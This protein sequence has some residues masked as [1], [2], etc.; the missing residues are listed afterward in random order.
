L[1]WP[2]DQISEITIQ[3][4][5]AANDSQDFVVLVVRKQAGVAT[6]YEA[7]FAHTATNGFVLTVYKR[8]AGTPTQIAQVNN[9]TFSGTGNV[10]SFAALGS[11]LS[12]YLN[13][14]RIA[15]V[16]DATLTGGSPGFYQFTQTTVANSKVSAW[17]GYNAVQQDGIWKKQ[18]IALAPIAGDLTAGI[19]CHS[20]ILREGNAQVL[21]G[22]VYKMWFDN[23]AGVF[24]AE[25]TD[26]INWTRKASAVLAGGFTNSA[27]YKVGSTYYLYVEP[28]SGPGG[29][30]SVYTSSDGIT[31]TLQNSSAIAAGSVGAWDSVNLGGLFAVT[32]QAGTW[33]G[34]YGGC[35]DLTTLAFSSGL[36]TSSD[37]I[38]WVKS[39]S[40]PVLNGKGNFF[41]IIKVGGTYYA[42]A[43][44]NQPGQG[45]ANSPFF[46][47]SE[48]RRYKSTDLINWSIDG[49]G[50]SI[51]NG[52]MCESLN[53]NTGYAT[54]GNFINIGGVAY[55]YHTSGPGDAVTPIIGQIALAIGPAP[56][57]QIVLQPEDGTQQ[58]AT[59]NF[60]GTL[61]NWTTPAG[62]HALQIVGG[63]LEP[64]LTATNCLMN[65]TGSSL[66]NDQ[67]SEVTINAMVGSVDFVGPAV[68]SQATDGNC[69]FINLAGPVNSAYIN[70]FGI[71]KKVSGTSTL[72]GSVLGQMTPQ[73][74]D[75]IRLAARGSNPVLLSAYQNGFLLLQV[76][77]FSNAYTSGS[78]AVNLFANTTLT[79]SQISSWA[80]GNASFAP[81]YPVSGGFDILF[82]G[83][84]WVSRV[85]SGL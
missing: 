55:S 17:R 33:Y 49:S 60:S 47:P 82:Q 22:T 68:R 18:G 77:D 26:G 44:S 13:N 39:G 20:P 84:L 21:S 19:Q 40:N 23:F 62:G 48:S 71:Y 79:N 75:V 11:V 15:Y 72:I 52:Q 53:I 78:P 8:I 2:N 80:G 24:Y 56:I 29:P 69:Y 10:L 74:G 9:V 34:F 27:V 37:G 30:I 64:T 45:N 61:A 67:Y 42:W 83:R 38:T 66:P 41:G 6:H 85:V 54:E 36:A 65:Y 59:D 63:K 58:T 1:T 70:N 7:D 57:E 32:V 14:K 51:R 35:K 12:V 50:I 5:S 3:S 73:V 46:D 43:Q 4:L 76:E 28:N 25:S 16:G 81:S 31:W